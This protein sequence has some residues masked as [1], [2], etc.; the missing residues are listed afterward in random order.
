MMMLTNMQL[1]EFDDW[2]KVDVL[3]RKYTDNPTVQMAGELIEAER[4]LMNEAVNLVRRAF[5]RIFIYG[6]CF[7]GIHLH[8][9]I[10]YANALCA[11]F[12]ED[13]DECQSG[14]DLGP[15]VLMAFVSML[16]VL[17]KIVNITKF[18]LK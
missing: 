15:G 13:S 11:V 5:S 17:V 3:L 16:L 10:T 2:M 4:S 6:V 18:F 14:K 12:K 9:Q 8:I 7:Y 1:V